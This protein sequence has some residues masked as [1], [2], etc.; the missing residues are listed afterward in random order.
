METTE[1]FIRKIL[2][3]SISNE[4]IDKLL[5]RFQEVF[6]AVFTTKEID[7]NFNY[8]FFEQLGDLTINKF[9]VTYASRKFPHLRS[10]NGVGVLAKIRILYGS[11]EELSK[12]T[13]KFGFNRHI[14]CTKAEAADNNKLMS[15]L[16]D[17]FEAFFGAVEFTMDKMYGNGIGYITAYKILES[18]YDEID[19]NIDYEVL[20]DFKSRLNEL[21]DEHKIGIRYQDIKNADETFTSKIHLTY[22]DY[23]DVIIATG[24]SPVKKNAQT[25]AAEE[26][27]KWISENLNIVKYVPNKY[28]TLPKKIW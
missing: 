14:I 8:E 24:T 10:S 25:A 11:K 19:L 5:E 6:K 20:V 28:K 21:K 17:V 2:Q 3:R 16:E 12:L 4:V 26:A 13:E 22:G 27:L 9:I 15:I 1:Q 18:M 7:R 23:N